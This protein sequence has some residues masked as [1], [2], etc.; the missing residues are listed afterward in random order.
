MSASSI[1]EGIRVSTIFVPT[2]NIADPTV[3]KERNCSPPTKIGPGHYRTTTPNL[4]VA[5]TPVL[6]PQASVTRR[7]ANVAGL[8]RTVTAVIVVTGATA[9]IDIYIRDVAADAPTDDADYVE[10]T[11]EAL[12]L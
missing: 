7:A 3:H 11:I 8:T 6:G 2:P 12:P 1:R 4:G 10:C 5:G 9:V